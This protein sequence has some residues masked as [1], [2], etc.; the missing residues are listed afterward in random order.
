MIYIALGI[1]MHDRASFTWSY[2]AAVDLFSN[3]E[4]DIAFVA[5]HL[6]LYG[7]N[8]VWNLELWLW[9]KH[10]HQIIIILDQ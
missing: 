8:V 9:K 1:N 7:D 3:I 4:K 6:Q 10:A 2:S 5:R